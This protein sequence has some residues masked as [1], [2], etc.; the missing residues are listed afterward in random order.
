MTTTQKKY[1]I[2]VLAP[3]AIGLIHAITKTIS[4]LE[5]DL[6]DTRQQVLQ[7]YFSMVLYGAFPQKISIQNIHNQLQKIDSKHPFEISIKPAPEKR[8][9]TPEP[10]DSYIL[11]ARGID[12]IGFVA[13]V[14]GFCKDNNLNIVDLSTTAIDE[15]Y[16]MI[17]LVDISNCTAPDQLQSALEQFNQ[18][19]SLSLLL[20]HHDIFKATNEI[21]ML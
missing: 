19:H 6:T 10:K 16:T 17:L 12:R 13:L 2:S 4:E 14:S 1:I 9:T 7:G 8:S 5:G 21:I 20:Q 15:T 3:D 18:K 11:T